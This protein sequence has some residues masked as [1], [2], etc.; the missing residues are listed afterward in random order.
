MT[1]LDRIFVRLTGY[2]TL[3]ILSYSLTK[4]LP[5]AFFLALLLWVL[6]DRGLLLLFSR[7]RSV[8]KMSV[9]ELEEIFAVQGVPYQRE[10]FLS[11]IPPYFHPELRTNGVFFFLNCRRYLL[12]P[13]YKFSPPSCDDIAAAYRTAKGDQVEKIIV[14]GKKCNREIL[15]FAKKFDMEF[16]FYPTKKVIDFLYK[17]NKVPSPIFQKTVWK[18]K[19]ESSV[20]FALAQ[21]RIRLSTVLKSLKTNLSTLFS[22]AL[23]KKR[24]KYYFFSALSMAILSFLVPY[25]AYYILFSVLS[26]S[27]GIACLVRDSA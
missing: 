22:E 4:S 6:C 9:R 7:I 23:T 13:C 25:R 12:F 5:A 10:F 3:L 15:L 26:F 17:Q 20:L 27:L 8:K 16:V 21:K 19:K 24:A 11:V 1:L 2:L 18:R 14:L